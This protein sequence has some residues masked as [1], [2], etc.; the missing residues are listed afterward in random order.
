MSSETVQEAYALAGQLLGMLWRMAS[1][2]DLLEDAL[3]LAEQ[4]VDAVRRMLE[5]VAHTEVASH[6]VIAPL[7]NEA[8]SLPHALRARAVA[9]AFL[10]QPRSSNGAVR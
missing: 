9:M 10:W 6:S 8:V 2:G 4:H 1:E 7:V 3:S 5:I